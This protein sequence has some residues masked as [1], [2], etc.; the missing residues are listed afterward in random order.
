MKP[1]RSGVVTDGVKH[2]MNPFDEIAVEEAMR[3][4]EKK[5]AADVLAVSCGPT[6]SQV[7]ILVITCY[8]VAFIRLGNPANGPGY[9][10]RSSVAHRSQ[11][12]RLREIG[13]VSRC[14][15]FQQNRTKG[16]N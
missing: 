7:S 6:A 12:T 9:G 15:T 4:K 5:W 3:M 2:S 14:S 8:Q 1:D 13:A 11:F 16:R 10:R